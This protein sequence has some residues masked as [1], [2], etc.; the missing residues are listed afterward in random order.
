MGFLDNSKSEQIKYLE[1]G[2]FSHIIKNIEHVEA[3]LGNLK[4]E[5]NLTTSYFN[6][7]TQKLLSDQ[8]GVGISTFSKLLYFCKLSIDG[9]PCLIL[10]QRI[11]DVLGKKIY[12]QFQEISNIRYENALEKYT[13]YLQ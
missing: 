11:I 3:V 7:S 1:G 12:L 10:D 4:N 8:N 5:E 6:E 9:F 13:N 2:H